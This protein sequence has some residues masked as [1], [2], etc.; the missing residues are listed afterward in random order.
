MQLTEGLHR[1]WDGWLENVDVM[2]IQE[3]SFCMRSKNDTGEPTIVFSVAL[4]GRAV[5]SVALRQGSHPCTTGPS[6][7]QF[8]TMGQWCLCFSGWAPQGRFLPF[9]IKKRG[10]KGIWSLGCSRAGEFITLCFKALKV[11]SFSS[12]HNIE[13]KLFLL[14]K[15]PGGEVWPWKRSWNPVLAITDQLR[16]P[17]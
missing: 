7:W 8:C 10:G 4:P 13:S 11:I 5:A 12:S 1:Q 9:H 3:R 2:K 17:R 15:T 16:K 6:C 14:N